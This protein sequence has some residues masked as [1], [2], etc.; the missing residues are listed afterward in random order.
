MLFGCGSGRRNTIGHLFLTLYYL[1]LQGIGSRAETAM[2][3]SH[4]ANA[5][6]L[7]VSL[8]NDTKIDNQP[9]KINLK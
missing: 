8:E 4:I 2:N 5:F 6:P 1:P 7:A 9:K 3:S